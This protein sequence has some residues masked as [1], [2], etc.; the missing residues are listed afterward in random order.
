MAWSAS[1]PVNYTS[2]GDQTKT[3]ISKL[4]QEIDAIYVK[5]NLLRTCEATETLPESPE[6]DHIVYDSA[7][8]VLKHWDAVG[9][10]WET[11]ND[12]PTD[13]DAVGV[14]VGGI[15]IWSGSVE[16]IPSGWH[17]CDGTT[18]GEVTCPDLRD[19]F[20]LGAGSTYAVGATGGAATHTLTASEMPS[21]THTFT[22][23]YTAYSSR[24]YGAYNVAAVNSTTS[25][26]TS[27]A[28]SGA[29]HNNMPPYYALAYI[30]RTS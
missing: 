8:N 3:A 30:M 29:A 7:N 15:V 20:V 11:I 24:Q 25:G 17:L 21:H 2:G 16:S 12:I 19:K 9:E 14:P 6:T 18:V 5:L 27:S 1:Y 28:G 22:D 26:T 13:I 4:K 10:E 23:T